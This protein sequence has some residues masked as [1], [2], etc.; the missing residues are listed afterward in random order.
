MSN[1][2]IELSAGLNIDQSV[3][4]IKT[5][6][7]SVQK[8]LDSAGIKISLKAE[9]LDEELKKSLSKI[10]NMNETAVIG[11]KMGDN[12]ATNLINAYNIKSKEAQRQIKTTMSQLY[13]MTLGEVKSGSENPQFISTLDKLGN[14]IINNA[15]IIQSRMGIYD[16][17]Y[18]YFKGISKIKIP[19]IVRQD[20]GKD[21]NSMRM[22]SAKTF[23]TK[24]GTELD[25]IYQELS[26][27]FKEHFS[28]TAD[29]TEQFRE[30]PCMEYTENNM[31]ERFCKGDIVYC[32]TEDRECL[33]IIIEIGLIPEEEDG[34]KIIMVVIDTSSGKW[35]RSYEYVKPEEIVFM[36]RVTLDEE[37][38]QEEKVE[39]KPCSLIESMIGAYGRDENYRNGLMDNLL[40]IRK[41]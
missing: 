5:D 18:K 15:N 19:D 41:Q 35:S 33:G 2:D 24:S 4:Q 13:D 17:F 7:A 12:L 28:G 39:K 11:K 3:Q 10:G 23:T 29:P 26:D 32:G 8:R 30:I 40:G 37:Q 20:L 38:E 22:V 21:W 9:I 36:R 1:V 14:V 25:S 31:T 6:I 34:E 16:E 27:K